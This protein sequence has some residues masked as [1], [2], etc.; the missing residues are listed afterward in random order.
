MKGDFSMSGR[1]IYSLEL[2]LEVVQRYLE[3]DI[4]LKTLAREYHIN[5]KACIQ[6][7]GTLYQEH[8]GLFEDS[9]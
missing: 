9:R 7:W 5:S 4:G 6:K 1:K 8:E 2:K 3:G